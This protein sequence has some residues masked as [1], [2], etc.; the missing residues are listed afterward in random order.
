M[1]R[2]RAGN[3]NDEGNDGR[4]TAGAFSAV[5]LRRGAVPITDAPW[6]ANPAGVVI[7]CRL[8]PKGGRDAFDGI[9]ALADGARVLLARVS[10]APENGRANRAL[11]E[12]LATALGVAASRVTIVAGAKGRL[13]RVA[14]T[15]EPAALIER[16]RAL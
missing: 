15:G 5:R 16:M 11:C 7:A 12:L 14:V 1:N 4:V 10:A 9:A 3:G 13:K 8:T 2:S 6:T